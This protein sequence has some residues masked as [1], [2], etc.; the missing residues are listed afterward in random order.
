MSGSRIKSL[1]LSMG[2]QTIAAA[3]AFGSHAAIAAE[4]EA[5]CKEKDDK[6]CVTEAGNS[7]LEHIEIHGVRNSVYRYDR[8][9]D[10]RRVADL[11]DTPQTISVLTLDQIQ[12][13][14]KTDLEDILAAQSGVTLGTGET[15]MPSATAISSAAMKRAAM[16]LSTA[17]AIRA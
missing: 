6:S 3:L 12:E 4:Q 16:Y 8:S 14:G 15:V 13:S 11:V 5:A 7:L 9:G 1:P 17:C 10:P 2:A